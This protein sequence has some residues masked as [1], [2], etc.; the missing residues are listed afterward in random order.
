M[1]GKLI[2]ESAEEDRKEAAEKEKQC[3]AALL[4][5]ILATFIGNSF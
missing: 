4:V 3:I 1:R 5:F 2:E